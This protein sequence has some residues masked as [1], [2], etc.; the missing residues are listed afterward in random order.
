[1]AASQ[2]IERRKQHL[3]QKHELRQITRS[4]GR[5]SG[6][7]ISWLCM[8]SRSLGSHGIDFIVQPGK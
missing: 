8:V 2:I 4:S 6:F 1:L 5:I 3:Q 7:A